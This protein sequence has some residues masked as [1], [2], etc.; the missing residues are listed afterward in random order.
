MVAAQDITGLVLAGGQGSRM[1]GADKGLL[2]FR[3]MALARHALERLRPQVSTLM[4][5]ANRNLA[6]YER[7]GAPVW[8][9]QPPVEAGPLAGLRAGL[10]QCTTP[11]LA[12]VPCDT[13][14]F[15]QDLVAR[16]TA[17]ATLAATR[18][19]VAL[20]PQAD[21]SLRR[22]PVFCLV[23]VSLLPGLEGFLQDGGRKVGEWIARHEVAQAAFNTPADDANAFVNANT[24]QELA[25]LQALTRPA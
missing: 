22:Q 16:L 21:G 18:L 5:S 20:A 1:G 3:G 7:F 4:L 9:D 14:L 15:P 8:P 10:T 12:C 23:H 24:L 19:A 25:R 6:D 13:P 17:A 11:W 2:P